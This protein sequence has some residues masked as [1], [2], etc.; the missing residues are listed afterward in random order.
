MAEI[1][2]KTP[3][4]DPATD[5][6]VASGTIPLDD[7]KESTK[8]EVNQ[9]P[10]LGKTMVRARALVE[11]RFQ[12]AD[13]KR[14][15]W[16]VTCEQGTTPEQCLH[17][18]FWANLGRIL[19][20]GDEIQILPDDQTWRMD[21]HVAGS[22]HNFAHV[23]KLRLYDLTP[24]TPFVKLPSIYKVEFA[25]AY[26]KWRFLREGKMMQDGFETEALARRAAANHESAV[27]R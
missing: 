9:E 11:S 18:T 15:I 17:E 14:N 6:P 7:E 10:L 1:A 19:K 21:V 12:L 8:A 22:G 16:R 5:Q 24:I 20:S 3:E 25:G 26:L 2:E 4:L 13:E 27:Q 23:V